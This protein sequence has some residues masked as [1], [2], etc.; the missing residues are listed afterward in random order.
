MFHVLVIQLQY[1][2]TIR[3]TEE[4]NS[5]IDTTESFIICSK[6]A[7]QIVLMLMAY[8]RTFSIS[9]APYL[10]AYATY[11]SAT[12]HVRDA[13]RRP[14]SPETLIYLRTCLSLMDQN[15]VTNPGIEKAK[16]SLADLMSRLGVVC[17]VDPLPPAKSSQTA[18]PATSRSS[19]TGAL[20]GFWKRPLP[21]GHGLSTAEMTSTDPMAQ[22]LTNMDQALVDEQMF[23]DFV[24]THPHI[25]YPNSNNLM[26]A[27]FGDADISI[28][29]GFGDMNSMEGIL[30]DPASISYKPANATSLEQGDMG[31]NISDY[32]WGD[33]M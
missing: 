19:S 28:Q 2:L 31:A 12:I 26:P 23:H 24:E 30:L 17:H 13:A 11:V 21:S 32:S 16:M 8:N 18:T 15:Q 7:K 9:K 29:L 27:H 25:P 3:S 33:T 5:E 10:I 6:A 20:P 22:T 1:P 4:S 14:T